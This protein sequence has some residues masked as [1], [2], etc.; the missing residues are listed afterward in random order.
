[1]AEEKDRRVVPNGTAELLYRL[2]DPDFL[3]H[4]RN[5]PLC[6]KPLDVGFVRHAQTQSLTALTTLLGSGPCEVHHD[7][8]CCCAVNSRCSSTWWLTWWP[9]LKLYFP[10]AMN[11]LMFQPWLL[12][13]DN[14]VSQIHFLSKISKP[15]ALS[16]F[17]VVSEKRM[18]S[19]FQSVPLQGFSCFLLFPPPLGF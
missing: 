6:I 2:W 11:F 10:K 14:A 19:P 3:L 17:H 16:F 15:Y 13:R 9:W 8:T 12:L 18:T 5:Q 4:K 1:M 7:V